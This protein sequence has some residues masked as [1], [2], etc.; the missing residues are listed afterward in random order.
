MTSAGGL[1]PGGRGRRAAGRAAAVGA[2]RRRAGRRPR[3]RP[4][5]ASPTPS[6]STWAARAPTCAWSSA[7]ARS[8]RPSARSAASRCGCRR[9]TCTPSAPAAGRS[10]G[11][12]PAARWWSGPQSA[13]ADPGPACYGRGGDDADG[14]RR[15]P[16]RRAHPGRRRL[17]RP[18]GSTP[19]AARGG[20][21]RA[22]VDRRGRGRRG[23][24]QHGA[25]AAGRVG[26]AGRRPPGP[27]AGG[28]RRRRA[29]ARLRAGRR[30]RDAGRGRAGPGGVLS[31]VGL[32]TA[33]RRRDL[34]RSWP[35]PERP[36]RPRRRRWR[37]WRPRPP[38][39]W[40]GRRRRRRSRRRSTAAT[41][42]EPRADRGRRS[43]RSP[44][45]TGAATATPGPTT[46]V[47]VVALRAAATGVRRRST[48]A[49]LP[50]A[51][52][53]GRRGAS[54]PAVIAEPDCTIWVP[55]GWTAAAPARAAAPLLDAG[56]ASDRMSARSRRRCRC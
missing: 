45:S 28:L 20:P 16:G 9:S 37:R 46:P 11:S 30:P 35:T 41:G 5:T 31:A 25:G 49:D 54:G 2:G 14:H 6:P 50:T 13:G 47:E 33:P 42:P 12:T 26:R 19:A 56:A 32:L 21:G 1:L 53:V 55:D 40:A 10:P 27:G 7:G 44:T 22:G 17:R 38:G 8:R 15:R 29:A 48:A 43:T 51:A 39:W 24:R 34:V 23:R 3:P 52:R 18:G 36:R 4:P